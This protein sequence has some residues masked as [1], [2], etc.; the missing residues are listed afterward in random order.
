MQQLNLFPEPTDNRQRLHYCA[1]HNIAFIEN[2]YWRDFAHL[3]L[4]ERGDFLT[5]VSA[6][7]VYLGTIGESYL[8][9]AGI[10]I[11]YPTFPEKTIWDISA[12]R[13][14]KPNWRQPV[15]PEPIRTSD[16]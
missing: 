7:P 12:F 16:L 3:Y 11:V 1:V 2:K 13:N 9:L 6:F 15:V 5:D 8:R 4:A 14:V 10:Q